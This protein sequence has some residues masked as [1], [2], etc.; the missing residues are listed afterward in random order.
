MLAVEELVVTVMCLVGALKP[1]SHPFNGGEQYILLKKDTFI[2]HWDP[3]WPS[4][5]Y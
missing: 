5:N 4:T 1:V 3:P 2:Y